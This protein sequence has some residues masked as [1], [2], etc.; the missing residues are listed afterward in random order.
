MS[1][2]KKRPIAAAVIL[3]LSGTA[4]AL[5]QQQT[6]PEVKV[7]AP[8]EGQGFKTDSTSTATR[9]DTP[10]RDIP[11]FINTVPEPV[12]RQQAI[13]S[14]SEALRNVPGITMTAAEGGVSA[15]QIFWLRGFPVA[16]DLFLDGVRDIGEYNRDLFNI[17]QVEVL[18]GPSA[19]AFGRGSTGGVINQVQKRADLLPRSEAALVVGTNGEL[20]ATADANFVLN[21]TTA[22]RFQVLGEKTDTYRDTIQNNQVGFAPSLRFGIGT[23]LDVTFNYEY[24]QTRSKTDYGQPNLG[25]TFGYGMPPVPL[26]RYYGFANYDYTNWYTNIATL[27]VQWK[28][29]ESV[30]VR[31]V[32]R[33]ASY[34]RDM[35]ASIGSL[36]TT[37]LTGGP[38]NV[39]TPFDQLAVTLTHNKAR[40]T[41]DQVLINQTDVTWKVATGSIKHTVTGGLDLATERLD[42]TTY[43]FDGNPA[44]AKIDAPSIVTSY[45]NPNINGQL[46]Y[47]KLPQNRNVSDADTIAVYVQDQLEFTREWKAV[48]G[49][50]YDYYDTKT[51]Q[52]ANGPAGANAGPF[53][54]SDNLWSG[55]A[56]L[57]WQPTNRQSYY[58]SWS[59][60]YNPSGELGV[61]GATATNL[62]VTNQFLDPEETYN[63]E[64]GGQWDFTPSLRLRSAIF[65]TEKTNA[66]ITDPAD[67]IMKLSGRRRVDGVE[68]ELAGD[69]TSRWSIYSG[70]AYMDGK[71]LEGDALTEGKH[72]TAAPWSGSVWTSYRF[73]GDLV[74]WQIAGG[75]FG[76]TERWIDDQNRGKIPDYLIWNA[77]VGY[78]Q[79]KYDIQFNVVNIFDTKY[80]PGGY[81]NNPNRVL[82]GQPLTGLLTLRYRFN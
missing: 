66:R 1:R 78:F 24:L 14:L 38:V 75:A 20:R 11:Q 32:T 45:L 29:S 72:M 74:G 16:G 80:Y 5:A 61:Y 55:R 13:Q 70:L 37:T 49:I 51:N 22:L 31:N 63:Y 6:L 28:A 56:G 12:I 27:N 47:S 7:T 8:P 2:F 52:T 54:R 19:L 58:A 21:P 42:R 34:K 59:N 3:M 4:P 57:I 81:Q 48:L 68:M 18:K 41:D 46:N 33:W 26:T 73:A 79:P 53:S 65:R 64:V 10:L 44:T 30:S 82:P 50:R 23:D 25:P 9:T 15:S 71:I 76:A 67:G 36:N 69:I 35:E 17:E 60:G 39:G 62:S 77:M 43:A 40:D